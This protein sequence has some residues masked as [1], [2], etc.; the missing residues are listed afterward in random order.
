MVRQLEGQA[1]NLG[2]RGFLL[3]PT[4]CST[5][6]SKKRTCSSPENKIGCSRRVAEPIELKMR[7]GARP[8]AKN[9]RVKLER[10]AHNLSAAIS[11]NKRH[12]TESKQMEMVQ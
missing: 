9:V 5:K 4:A 1:P 11:E 3:V 8:S 12:R 10:K 7:R 2:R 6:H